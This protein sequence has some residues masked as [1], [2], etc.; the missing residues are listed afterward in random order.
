MDVPDLS[1]QGRRMLSL[2]AKWLHTCVSQHLHCANLPATFTP[3]RLISVGDRNRDP[4][5]VEFE[6]NDVK[7]YAA[8]SYCWGSGKPVLV[9]Q[10][11]NIDEHLQAIRLD[12]LPKVVHMLHSLPRLCLHTQDHSRR[13][14]S[15]S[16]SRY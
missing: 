11:H 15:M 14:L 7:K 6:Q 16:L 9:T 10:R 1:V 12:L 3:R 4:H 5:L 13:C 8:L 2:A